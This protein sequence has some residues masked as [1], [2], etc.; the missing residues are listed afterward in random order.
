MPPP[1]DVPVIAIDGPSAS[2]KGTIAQG[3]AR[4]LGFH[5]L[6]SGAL[7]RLVALA[8]RRRGIELTAEQPLAQVAAGLD[9][10][11]EGDEVI[12][13]GERV[14]DTIRSEPVSQDASKVASH[15]QV[16]AALMARQRAFR[17]PPG[18]VAE[19]RD[20]GTHVFPDARLKIFLTASPEERAR[21]RYK[22]LIDKGMD[23]TMI[24]LVRDIAERD[25]RDRERAV[26]PLKQADDAVLIDTTSLTIDEIVNAVV[27]RY[28]SLT[29]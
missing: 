8:A 29:S 15:P 6:D 26:A 14:T 5:Y 25:R 28:R 21:R 22:Q 23:V 19:G 2:G 4:V 11:F 27:A 13:D 20:M 9:A 17:R 24:D 7:Y 10:S 18:L 12:L 1:E 3:V 16:R